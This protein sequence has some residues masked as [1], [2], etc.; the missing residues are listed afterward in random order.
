MSPYM[1]SVHRTDHNRLSDMMLLG[2]STVR[3]MLGTSLL[4]ANKPDCSDIFF[5]RLLLA[6]ANPISQQSILSTLQ[7]PYALSV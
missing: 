3:C 7:V 1:M 4:S 5:I 6:Y 2:Q